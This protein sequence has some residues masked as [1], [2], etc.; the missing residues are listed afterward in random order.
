[1]SVYLPNKF[2][3]IVDSIL[4]LLVICTIIFVVGILFLV[5]FFKDLKLNWRYNKRVFALLLFNM[6]IVL[7]FLYNRPHLLL[8]KIYF[9]ALGI[10]FI[11]IGIK[12]VVFLKDHVLFLIIVTIFNIL[13]NI[14]ILLQ[15]QYFITFL[16]LLNQAKECIMGPAQKRMIAIVFISI[17]FFYFLTILQYTLFNIEFDWSKSYWLIYYSYFYLFVIIFIYAAILTNFRRLFFI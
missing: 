12:G 6:F 14:E 2:P 4:S 3:F 13:L 9:S 15:L 7:N 5:L 11:P 10:L 17:A 8:D 16:I 1:M